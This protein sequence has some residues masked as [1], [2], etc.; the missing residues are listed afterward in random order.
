MPLFPGIETI[1]QYIHG[2]RWLV[3]AS[4]CIGVYI[5]VYIRI[6]ICG[7]GGQANGI[8]PHHEIFRP[9]SGIGKYIVTTKGNVQE[10]AAMT[11]R[12]S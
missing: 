9:G 6:R 4:V 1:N 8:E 7:G 2:R 3:V 5:G 12:R 10:Y 11:T